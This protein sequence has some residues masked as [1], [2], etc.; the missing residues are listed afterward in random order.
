MTYQLSSIYP[1]YSFCYY[2]CLT[3]KD[4]FIVKAPTNNSHILILATFSFQ[5][6]AITILSILI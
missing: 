5:I 4:K 3:G 6:F 1:Y 2:F